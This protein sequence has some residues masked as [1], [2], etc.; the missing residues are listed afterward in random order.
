M[1]AR[2]LIVWM[3]FFALG[4]G[5]YLYLKFLFDGSDKFA[6]VPHYFSVAYGYFLGW[7]LL[8]FL[9]KPVRNQITQYT[10][11]E[12]DGERHCVLTEITVEQT[13]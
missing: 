3:L 12:Y 6:F 2:K 1:K 11:R 5:L 13:G 4:L 7:L 8:K 9:P 10:R